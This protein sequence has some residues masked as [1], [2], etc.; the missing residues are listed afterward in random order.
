MRLQ[1]KRLALPLCTAFA[2]FSLSLV[3]TSSAL[4][5]SGNSAPD[6]NQSVPKPTPAP[7]HDPPRGSSGYDPVVPG[8]K[9]G[10]LRVKVIDGRTL[11][12]LPDAEVVV[13][14]TEQRFRTGKD[15]LTPWIKAPVLRSAR[16][17]FLVNELHGQ[18]NLISYKNG[19]RD[20]V[21]MGVRMNEGATTRT[22]IWQYKI[23]PGLDR[24]VEPVLFIE[25]YHRLW[26]IQLADRFRRPTQLG[27]GYEHP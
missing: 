5:A 2:L 11:K 10:D 27:E 19:Y 12:P 20:S 24:R 17:R 9:Y 8:Q 21:H 4:A 22:T 7:R 18:L 14:E 6:T 3:T 1:G 13:L 16:F 26:L 23:E 25:P 15:G